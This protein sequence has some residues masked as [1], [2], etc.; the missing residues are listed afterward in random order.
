MRTYSEVFVF[1][2]IL[3]LPLEYGAKTTRTV[4]SEKN[5]PPHSKD[6]IY[7]DRLIIDSNS[8]L[9]LQ[10]SKAVVKYDNS[11]KHSLKHTNEIAHNSDHLKTFSQDDDPIVMIDL[12]LDDET[13]DTNI[14]DNEN[15]LPEVFFKH[16][17]SPSSK[18]PYI[19]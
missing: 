16:I 14:E 4:D 5:S 18:Y 17:V 19:N 6:E 9:S 3:S 12:D 1:R 13:I 8:L 7:F 11:L 15:S 10:Q 2:D